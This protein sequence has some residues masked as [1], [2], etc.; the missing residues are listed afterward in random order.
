MGSQLEPLTTYTPI[1]QVRDSQP[2]RAACFHPSGEAYVVGSNSKALRICRYPDS[3]TR[4]YLLNESL[5]LNYTNQ[6]ESYGQRL[7]LPVEPEILFT[8]LHIHSGSVYCATFNHDGSL[9]ATGSNDQ[10][11]HLIRYNSTTHAPEGNEY[12]LNIHSGTIR[13]VCFL[14]ESPPSGD[15]WAQSPSQLQKTSN[16][17]V[18]AGAGEFEVNVSDCNVMKCVHSFRGHESA[19]MSLHSSAVSHNNFVS[20]SLD[21]TIRLWDLRCKTSVSTITTC[22]AK[23]ATNQ[24][25]DTRE[26]SQKAAP[27]SGI[28]DESLD[29]ANLIVENKDN[30]SMGSSER[31]KGK[32]SL[33]EKLP[34][35]NDN[36]D[37]STSPSVAPTHKGVPVGCVRLDPSGRL[38]VSGH[39]DG[40]CM[41]FDIRAGKVIQLFQAHEGEIRALNFSPKSYYL[42]TG[43][44]DRKVRL[45]DMQGHLASKLPSV[46]VAELGDKCVQVAWHPF[47]YNFVTTCADGSANL[48]TIP[49]FDKWIESAS[50]SGTL[51]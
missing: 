10:V 47:D 50:R 27:K 34:S 18:S 13:D 35:K 33:V 30:S 16:R 39:Q 40:T 43:S 49:D 2:I 19:V 15:E 28:L 7:F 23:L 21:G 44:Y 45:V 37:R 48:W 3:E 25:V 8:C 17:L 26:S 4:E 1:Q 31:D 20:G 38:L 11:V 24:V 9:L 32:M 22:Q 36:C 46:E 12:K 29:L 5:S 51:V 6:S 42:L 41:L 14:A